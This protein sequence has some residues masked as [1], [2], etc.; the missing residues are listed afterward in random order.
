MQGTVQTSMFISKTSDVKKR[1]SHK[2]LH[3]SFHCTAGPREVEL[4]SRRA[5]N[6]EDLEG[7]QKK[8]FT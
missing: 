2:V 4:L 1:S 7:V 5:F 8:K 6:I 3:K